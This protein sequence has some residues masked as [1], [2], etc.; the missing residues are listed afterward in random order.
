MTNK[1]L[2]NNNNDKKYEEASCFSTMEAYQE[3][4]R[5][6]KIIIINVQK[7]EINKLVLN[8]EGMHDFNLTYHYIM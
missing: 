5:E 2:I 3:K 1:K 7:S 6:Q 8:I 4:I